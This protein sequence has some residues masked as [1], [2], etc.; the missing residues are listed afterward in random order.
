M[1]RRCGQPSTPLLAARYRPASP[2]R[3]LHRRKHDD[4]LREARDDAN[5]SPGKVT[6]PAGAGKT[7]EVHHVPASAFLSARGRTGS[8]GGPHRGVSSRTGMEPALQRRG[9]VRRHRRP[10]S[11]WP[12]HP[13]APASPPEG[14]RPSAPAVAA[15]DRL[16]RRR[17]ELTCARSSSA[18]ERP[19][20]SARLD[21]RAPSGRRARRAVA[22]HWSRHYRRQAGRTL[23]TPLPAAVNTR[24][25][26]RSRGSAPPGRAPGGRDLR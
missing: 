3:G 22:G 16:R 15:G 8:P 23:G 19:P 7:I 11:R 5:T 12:Q 14:D 9:G 2:G 25:P 18:S 1:S 20:P 6:A 10:A 4:Q 13:A 17:G 21:L 24:R 26:A